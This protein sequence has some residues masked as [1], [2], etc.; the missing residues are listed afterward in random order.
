MLS[1]LLAAVTAALA[2]HPAATADR[3]VSPIRTGARSAN[4]AT[5]YV[6]WVDHTRTRL[7]LYPSGVVPPVLRGRLLATFNGGFKP[8]AGAGGLVVDGRVAQPLVP[9]MGTLVEYRDGSL[10]I[11]DWQG[12]TPP[13]ALV[14]ARQNLP[15][16]VWNGRPT[17]RAYV[18]GLW[19]ATLGG[20]TAV[21]RTAVGLTARGDLVYAAA[22]AQTPLSL[23]QT[24][25]RLGAE[26]AIE[27]D[28]N[29][30]WPTFITYRGGR[31]PTK[32]VPNPQESAFRYLV[33]DSRDFF[34][35]YAR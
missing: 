19:G 7:A 16:L 23:A 10:A 25:A 28:I 30:E 31:D 1:G 34:A 9:G 22:N 35:V 6:A 3:G 20:G 21:W 5:A 8:G 14:L 17:S 4:G 27:L 26:R 11:L 15:P 18:P 32:L 24:M 2:L 12:R 33:P 29:P 13:G